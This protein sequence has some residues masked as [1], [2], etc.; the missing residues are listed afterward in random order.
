MQTTNPLNKQFR[1]K[2][3]LMAQRDA[4]KGCERF[5]K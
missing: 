2:F 1:D 3:L 4:S 5:P